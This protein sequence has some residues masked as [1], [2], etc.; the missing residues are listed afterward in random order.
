MRCSDI[1]PNLIPN[2][3]TKMPRVRKSCEGG[4]V[5]EPGKTVKLSPG[6][7]HLMLLELKGP[8]KRGDK[9]PITLEFEKAGKV[10]TTLDVEGIGAQGPGGRDGMKMS[11]G[12]QM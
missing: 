4:L 8:L 9:L 7:F 5:I 11:P 1:R 2:I 12:M 10:S 3:S 6:G